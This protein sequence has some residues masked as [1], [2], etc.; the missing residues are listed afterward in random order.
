MSTC[1]ECKEIITAIPDYI[2]C[3]NNACKT[4]YHSRCVGFSRIKLSMIMDSPNLFWFCNTC[5]KSPQNCPNCPSSP[6]DDVSIQLLTGIQ[7][8]ITKIANAI[9]KTPEWPAVSTHLVNGKRRRVTDSDESAVTEKPTKSQSCTVVIGSGNSNEVLQVVEPRKLLVAS[10][11]HPST[12]TDQL[13]TYLK[14]K[15]EIPLNSTE[16]R[17]NK[18]VSNGTDLSTL[19]YVSFKIDVPGHRFEELMSPALWP[20]G[21]RVREFEYRPRKSRS[22]AVFLTLPQTAASATPIPGPQLADV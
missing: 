18:L 2:T 20:K 5:C 4:V 6:A 12:E 8:S 16:V 14:E 15:L 1:G 22:T 19:D 3:S 7:D 21:V 17:V 13:A 9:A 11:L 10:M